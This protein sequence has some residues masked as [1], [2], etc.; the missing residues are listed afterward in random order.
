[1]CN[2]ILNLYFLKMQIFWLKIQVVNCQAN[3]IIHNPCQIQAQVYLKQEKNKE[4]EL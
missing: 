1:M 4:V 3:L 2:K